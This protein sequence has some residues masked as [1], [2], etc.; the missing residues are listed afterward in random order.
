MYVYIYG[1]GDWVGWDVLE[2]YGW[3]G[4]RERL[5]ELH[6]YI[7]FV[8]LKE[9]SSLVHETIV[10]INLRKRTKIIKNKQTNKQILEVF[11][12]K[13][14]ALFTIYIIL[15]IFLTVGAD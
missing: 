2:G 5:E 10:P 13:R 3:I 7:I 6:H 9:N 4:R 12:T 15:Q 8:T 11:K 1:W 14:N